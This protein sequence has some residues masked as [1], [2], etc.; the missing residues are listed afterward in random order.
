MA[1]YRSFYDNANNEI[2]FEEIF[3]LCN[4]SY[5][6]LDGQ[7]TVP[8][9]GEDANISSRLLLLGY[10]AFKITKPNRWS[11]LVYRGSDD[12]SDWALNN[13]PALIPDL[14]PSS[15]PPQYQIGLAH[16]RLQGD[17]N[18]VLV[19]HSLGGAI[20]SYAAA[21]LGWAAATIF[22]PPLQP[23]WLGDPPLAQGTRIQNYVNNLEIAT[24]SAWILPTHHR[25]GE[26][27]WIE[28]RGNPIERHR[29]S[30]IV[31]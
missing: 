10:A 4:R 27:V 18:T 29:R 14:I 9:A 6:D 24:M 7:H 11:A 25:Y 12:W 15:P 23:G 21:Q 17:P 5:D 19:G 20:A 2:T 30:S 1:R 3:D 31:L 22:P 26:D 8:I 13:I 28:S 16:A